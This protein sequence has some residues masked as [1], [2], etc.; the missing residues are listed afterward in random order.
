MV[1]S[2]NDLEQVM[3]GDGGLLTGEASPRVIADASTVS[4]DA[5]ALIRE[6]GQLTRLRLPGHAGQR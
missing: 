3:L 6:R 4:A 2:S 5:S 1:S